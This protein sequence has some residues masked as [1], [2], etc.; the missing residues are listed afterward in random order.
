MNMKLD[1]REDR[2]SMIRG[3]FMDS[4]DE[5]PPEAGISPPLPPSLPPSMGRGQTHASGSNY[6]YDAQTHTWD[7]PPRKDTRADWMFG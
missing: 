1:E 4:G 2:A 3:E 7:A 6:S 5:T